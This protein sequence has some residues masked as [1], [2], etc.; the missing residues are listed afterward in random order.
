MILKYSYIVKTCAP[1]IKAGVLTSDDIT[2]A[3]QHVSSMRETLKRMYNRSC[4]MAVDNSNDLLLA[5]ENDEKTNL[6]PTVIAAAEKHRNDLKKFQQK[7]VNANRPYQSHAELIESIKRAEFNE[8]SPVRQAAEKSSRAWEI[9]VSLGLTVLGVG[10][11]VGI[12][13]VKR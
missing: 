6:D 11:I 7:E 4:D 10:I 5:I 12:A 13:I 8:R 9:A 3:T 2:H 1:A